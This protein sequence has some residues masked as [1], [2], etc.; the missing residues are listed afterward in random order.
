MRLSALIENQLCFRC[1]EKHRTGDCE[2]TGKCEKCDKSHAT[3]L[4]DLPSLKPKPP[5][6]DKRSKPDAPLRSSDRES[7]AEAT[8]SKDTP[9]SA[10]VAKSSDDED[11]DDLFPFTRSYLANVRHQGSGKVL[12][13]I[14]MTDDQSWESYMHPDLAEKLDIGGPVSDYR[15]RTLGGLSSHVG[16]MEIKGLEVQAISGGP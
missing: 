11:S 2:Y 9:R 16:G 10:R 14:V 8:A 15:L 4:H 6:R 12:R 3:I 5:R 13:C 1:A 7:S